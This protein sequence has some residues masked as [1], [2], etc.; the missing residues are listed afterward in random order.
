M[1]SHSS[2]ST[3]S[4]ST[5]SLKREYTEILSIDDS[6]TDSQQD[7]QIN[8]PSTPPKKK[9]KVS[10]ESTISTPILTPISTSSPTKKHNHS[11]N[12]NHNNESRIPIIRCKSGHG[13]KLT[14]KE[15]KINFQIICSSCEKEIKPNEDYYKCPKNNNSYSLC[16]TCFHKEKQEYTGAITLGQRVRIKVR[17]EW[18]LGSILKHWPDDDMY[19]IQI[20]GQERQQAEAYDIYDA[21]WEIQLVN[22]KQLK[23]TPT[24]ILTQID[25]DSPRKTVP[26]CLSGCR[27]MTMDAE[28]VYKSDG[29]DIKDKSDDDDNDIDTG[30]GIFCNKCGDHIAEGKIYHCPNKSH[31]EGGGYDLCLKC[32]KKLSKLVPKK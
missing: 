31:L 32:C 23:P 3:N 14:K 19:T 26:R 6:Q 9:R 2:L 27:M 22:N 13:M 20:D 28:T 12:H 10:Y 4:T 29:D 11:H 18:K 15:W 24:R 8:L 30:G 7:S 25:S 16:I 21:F 5:D 17:N 1:S